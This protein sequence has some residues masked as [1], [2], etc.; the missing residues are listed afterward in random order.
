VIYNPVSGLAEGEEIATRAEARLADS[1]WSVSCRPTRDR[2]GATPIAAAVAADVDL[3][4]VVG[5]DGSIR[6]AIVG[7]GDARSH[8]LL[9][10]VPAGNANVVA[11]ELG[12]PSGREA[13]L[14]VLSSGEPVAV[15]LGIANAELFL[16]MVGVGWDALTVRYLSWLRHTR[17]GGAWYRLWADS[18]YVV[19]GLLAACRVGLGRL[20]L[21]ADGT[22]A[23]RR[24][25]AAIVCNFRTYGKG[26]TMAPDASFQSGRLHHQAR[27][28]GFAPFVV[29][30]VLAA[31]RGRRA[32]RFVSDYGDGEVVRIESERPMPMQIDGDFRGYV[33]ELDLE[34]RPGAVRILAPRPVS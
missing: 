2:R 24:Y 34:V 18:V 30:Q 8:V 7:L 9:G 15:D 14:D 20:R 33:T 21:L 32:P 16:A 28:R 3:L 25:C 6:E 5:G 27:F 31:M 26:W 23:A 1:G 13:A 17:F 19:A 10:I 11:R 4:V 29:L 22:E 12:I